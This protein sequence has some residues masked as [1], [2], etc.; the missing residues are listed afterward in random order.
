MSETLSVKTR[1]GLSGTALKYIACI[2]MLIDHIGA[3]CIE[4]GILRPALDAGTLSA[5][6]LASAPLYQ[7]DRVLRFTGRL[8]FPSSAFCWWRASSTPTT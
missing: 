2:T 1:C 7:L 8:A 5:D 6:A 3:S 4:A